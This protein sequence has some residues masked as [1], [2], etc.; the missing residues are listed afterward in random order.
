[1]SLFWTYFIL[2]WT[3]FLLALILGLVYKKRRDDDQKNGV[4]TCS[5]TKIGLLVSCIV[6]SMLTF[7]VLVGGSVH[8]LMKPTKKYSFLKENNN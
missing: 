4:P 1:M 8:I 2:F 3:F 5:N 7:M 6:F